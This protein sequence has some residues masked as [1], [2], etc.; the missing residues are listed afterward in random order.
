M[1]TDVQHIIDLIDQLPAGDRE[2][3]EQHLTERAELAW[4]QEVESARLDMRQRGIDQ[5]SI[6]DAVSRHRYGE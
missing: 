4:R 2:A 3:L 1:S 5:Q 6:D